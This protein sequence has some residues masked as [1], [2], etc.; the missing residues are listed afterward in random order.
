MVTEADRQAYHSFSW[1]NDGLEF[2]VPTV[3]YPTIDITIM[4][5]FESHLVAG[6]GFPSS[7]FLIAVMSYLGCELV[8]LNPNAIAALRYF[9]MLCEC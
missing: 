7:K 9:T 5:Y 4:V 2:S 6:L 1:L 3:K 8:H